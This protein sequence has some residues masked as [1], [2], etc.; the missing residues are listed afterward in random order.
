MPELA[1]DD[2]E[3]YAFTGE[4]DGVG[5][6]QLM[7]REAPPATRLGGKPTELDPDAGGS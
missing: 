3:R 4:L 1:L 5:M 6:A 7:R 2:V